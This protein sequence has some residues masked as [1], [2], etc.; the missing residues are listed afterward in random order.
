MCIFPLL[1]VVRG[2]VGLP[3]HSHHI[4]GLPEPLPRPLFPRGLQPPPAP[5]LALPGPVA[6][7][8]G[9][10]LAQLLQPVVGSQSVAR[11]RHRQAR[12]GSLQGG[13]SGERCGA[14]EHESPEV[15]LPLRGPQPSSV[16]PPDGAGL[17]RHIP[18][19]RHRKVT[20][21]VSSHVPGQFPCGF[22]DRK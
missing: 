13:G 22:A 17:S 8:G 7:D 1:P 9:Q 21:L 11:G 19:T 6:Q 2:L 14:R 15:L 10:D 4:P 16:C 5:D 20:V 18:T 12:Q 3:A